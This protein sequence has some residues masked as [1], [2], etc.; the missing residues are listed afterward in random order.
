VLISGLS[1]GGGCDNCDF[2]QFKYALKLGTVAL[3]TDKGPATPLNVTNSRFF[4]YIDQ[5]IDAF[6]VWMVPNADTAEA[7]GRGIVFSGCKFGN[8]G[9]RGS[10]GEG[11]VLVAKEDT[12]TGANALEHPHTTTTGGYVRGVTFRDNNVNNS[13]GTGDVPFVL[14]YTGNLEHWTVDDIIEDT[15]RGNY[16]KYDSALSALSDYSANAPTNS[17]SLRRLMNGSDYAFPQPVS[18]HNTWLIEDPHAFVNLPNVQIPHDGGRMAGDYLSKWSSITETAGMTVTNATSAAVANADGDTAE[19]IEVTATSG[20]GL[21]L[22]TFGVTSAGRQMWVTGDL[23][24]GS[25]LAITEVQVEIYT[26]SDVVLRRTYTLAD[27]WRHFCLP[28][29]PATVT[30]YAVRIRVND[31]S[32]G[33]RTK[34]RVGRLDVYHATKPFDRQVGRKTSTATSLDATPSIRGFGTLKTANASATTITNLDDGVEGQEV[35]VLIN[36]ANTTIDFTGT[37]LKGNAG[38]DWSPASGDFMRCRKIGANWYCSVV[39]ATA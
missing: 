24:Q 11:R 1:A 12:G 31:Y 13:N 2:Q 20:V 28:F 30:T 16:I 32:A 18:R 26:G 23:Q 37:T 21:C 38:V 4:R 25:S 35:L 15:Q 9:L 8:E 29:V 34:F 5:A 6:D 3:A 22:A 14:S 39:D 36:D 19:G 17:L 33:V 27:H 10:G 7:A